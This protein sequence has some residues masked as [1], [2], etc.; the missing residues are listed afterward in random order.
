MRAPRPF[1][2]WRWYRLVGWNSGGDVVASREFAPGPLAWLRRRRAAAELFRL[3]AWRIQSSR[4]AR[5]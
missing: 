1:K 5:P 3:G 2:R 4:V